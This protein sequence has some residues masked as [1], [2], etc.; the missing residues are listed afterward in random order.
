MPT[1]IGE[2]RVKKMLNNNELV[3]C[4][5]VITAGGPIPRG[6]RSSNSAAQKRVGPPQQP[7]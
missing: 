5:G 1:Q 7:V 4:L 3:L 6:A 2:N